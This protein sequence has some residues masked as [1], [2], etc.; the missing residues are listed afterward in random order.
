MCCRVLSE[1]AG[2]KHDSERILTRSKQ[3][4]HV[5]TVVQHTLLKGHILP[6]LMFVGQVAVDPRLRVAQPHVIHPGANWR[7]LQLKLRTVRAERAV[8]HGGDP[9]GSV[10][11]RATGGIVSKNGDRECAARRG[12]AGA[13]RVSPGHAPAVVRVALQRL[14]RGSVSAS[15]RDVQCSVRAHHAGVPNCSG[16]CHRRRRRYNQPIRGLDG[17]SRYRCRQRPREPRARSI[18]GQRAVEVLHAETSRLRQRRIRSVV[19]LQ[20]AARLPVDPR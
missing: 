11:V 13:V 4:R 18:D 17:G 16:L 2:S 19:A 7:R 9:C 15:V 1:P 6:K 8:G 10:P 20:S 3:A 14:R 12:A 5:Q